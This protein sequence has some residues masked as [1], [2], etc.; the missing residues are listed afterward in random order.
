MPRFVIL[1]H[2][3]PFPHWDLML[4]SGDRLSTWRLLEEP[5]PGTSVPAQR[6]DDHRLLYL[7]YEGPV[8]GGRGN[9]ARWD[10]GTFE[11][12]LPDRLPLNVALRGARLRLTAILR[13]S[14]DGELHW[15]FG[16]SNTADSR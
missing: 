11:S 1:T 5:A 6:L 13:E 4:E 10:S 7:E 12:T 3:H 14:P 16:S 2:D 8:S 15:A 9:V